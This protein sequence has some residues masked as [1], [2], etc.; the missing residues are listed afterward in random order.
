[1]VTINK[2]LR[3]HLLLQ[4]S[5]FVT[6]LLLL[7]VLLGYLVW[8]TRVQW[9]VSQNGR[10]S[11]SQTSVAVLKKL[12]G[13]IK[14]TA[15]TTGQ[16]VQFGDIQK[17]ISDFILLYQRVK[18]DISLAFVNSTEQPK[19]AQEAGV[20]VNGEMVITFDGRREHL[21]VIN[22]QAFTNV[23]MRLARS[24]E[25]MIVALTGHGERKLVGK[26]NYDLGEFGEQLQ[27]NGFKL[28][29]LN[30]AMVPDIPINTRVLIIAAPQTD[31]LAGEVE[32]LLAYIDRGG[33]LLWLVDQES[34]RGLLPLT[35]K[36]QLTLTPGIVLDPQA[37]QLK[38][39]TTFALGANYGQHAITDNFDYITVFPFARQITINENEDWHGVSLVEVAPHGW[40]ETSGLDG[41]ITFDQAY[42]VAGPVSIAAALTR[43]VQD[44]EQ[45]IVI[46]GS[47]HFLANTYLGNGGNLDFGVNLI[48]WLTGDE[49]LITIQPRATRDS[50][51]ILSELAL[52][53]IVVGFLLV[54]PFL[55]LVSG[56]FIWWRRRRK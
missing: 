30:L 33:N 41:E 21:T 26:A 54:L 18:P 7:V 40:V 11:L 28:G 14:V 3:L 46:V 17:I 19:Q 9:D 43:T 4:N 44:R 47:G 23:L 12:N 34:L 24:Q 10:N 25:K 29:A 49:S 20:S 6:L 32:K 50:N 31:L 1:M 8:E 36:L 45:R 35:E 2:K 52:T 15:Y 51:L 48:N 55:F 13:P 27:V 53:L 56:F 42:D 37:E 16:H 5:L 38:A 22:E 39:P